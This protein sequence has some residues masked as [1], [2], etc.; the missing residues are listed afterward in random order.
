MSET[1]SFYSLLGGEA[2]LRKICALFYSKM[3]DDVR[4]KEIRSLHAKSLHI[5]ESKLFDFLSGWLGGPSLYM[6]KYGHPRLRMRHLPFPIAERERD[7]WL[8]CMQESL[9][10]LK[11]NDIVGESAYQGLM[12]SFYKTAD[13]MRNTE[14]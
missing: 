6:Q 1:T 12:A 4:F 9:L 2:N 3:N 11:I 7:Q 13:F 10:E 8:L 14:S 5:S